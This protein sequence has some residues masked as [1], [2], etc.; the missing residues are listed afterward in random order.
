MAGQ[1]LKLKAASPM[2]ALDEALEY[3]V[4]NTFTKMGYLGRS[5]THPSR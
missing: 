3:L 2:A 5:T 4:K 1:P